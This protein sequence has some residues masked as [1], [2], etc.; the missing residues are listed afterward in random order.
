MGTS[1]KKRPRQKVWLLVDLMVE[2]MV[3]MEGTGDEAEQ[4]ESRK[5]LVNK[6]HRM[7]Q[8]PSD[9]LFDFMLCIG[10]FLANSIP[11]LFVQWNKA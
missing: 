11:P 7:A 6:N 10:Y 9:R 4:E 3:G 2:D 1:I 5:A 8:L